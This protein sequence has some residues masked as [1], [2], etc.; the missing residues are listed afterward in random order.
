MG[1][2]TVNLQSA[3]IDK[4]GA[5]PQQ[6]CFGISHCFCP[7]CP[8]SLARPSPGYEW[9]AETTIAPAMK[10]VLSGRDPAVAVSVPVSLE[11]RLEPA[12]APRPC[13][14]LQVV[15]ASVPADTS[16]FRLR[17][18]GSQAGNWFQRTSN[19]LQ[20]FAFSGTAS[21][22]AEVRS[23]VVNSFVLE[24]WSDRN[25]IGDST[26]AKVSSVPTC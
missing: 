23:P 3:I 4:C 7:H 22:T 2:P 19:K 15:G 8:N 6:S 26:T 9:L 10:K 18:T 17:P 25:D 20:R 12:S 1:I 13:T 11:A 14:E 16:W 5:A 21:R 24:A